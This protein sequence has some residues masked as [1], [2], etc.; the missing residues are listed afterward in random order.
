[1]GLRGFASRSEETDAEP[2]AGFGRWSKSDSCLQA[3]REEGKRVFDFARTDTVIYTNLGLSRPT[4]RRLEK[5]GRKSLLEAPSLIEL[6]HSRGRD[7]LVHRALKNPQAER[8]PFQ[9]FLPN[10]AFYSGGA[11]GFQSL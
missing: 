8:M 4:D 2:G 5:A 7:E 3:C 9:D 6:H 11:Q 1:M 10:M